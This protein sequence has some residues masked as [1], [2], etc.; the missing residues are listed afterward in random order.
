MN[1]NQIIKSS[2][3]LFTTLFLLYLVFFIKNIP[4]FCKIILIF[5]SIFHLY[6]TWWFFNNSSNAPI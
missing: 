2:Y 1:Q 6:D 4:L 5:I 3:H